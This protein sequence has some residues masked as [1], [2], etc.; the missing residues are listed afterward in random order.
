MHGGWLARALP[1]FARGLGAFLILGSP[2]GCGLSPSWD[3]GWVGHLE[4]DL[5]AIAAQLDAARAA[6]A[7]AC[8]PREFAAAETYLHAARLKADAPQGEDFHEYRL[9]AQRELTAAVAKLKGCPAAGGEAA[10]PAPKE[11]VREVVR[12][13]PVVRE[14]V[15]EVPREVVRPL[16]IPHVEVY[17]D[18]GSARLRPE[19][20][21]AIEANVRWLAANP[22]NLKVILEGH[23]DERGSDASNRTLA[24]RRAEAVRDAL[25]K[26]GLDGNR[27]QTVSYGEARPWLPG[28]SEAAWRWNRRVYFRL[29]A[30]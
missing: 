18:T 12:E 11:V 6:G 26:A 10:R 30:P 27:I 22:P 23:A 21:A 13:V 29:A 28:H 24:A 17:F 9:L 5:P 1:R 25:V 14:V 20:R 15:R 8:A 19:A 4:A 7:A 2:A 16:H 3:A